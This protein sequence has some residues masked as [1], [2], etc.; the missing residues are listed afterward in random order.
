[1]ADYYYQNNF[2]L[3]L[4]ICYEMTIAGLLDDHVHLESDMFTHKKYVNT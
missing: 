3:K 4:D 1:M 2:L